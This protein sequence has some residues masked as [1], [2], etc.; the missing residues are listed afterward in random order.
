MLTT[1]ASVQ[2]QGNG[3]EGTLIMRRSSSHLASRNSSWG[4][5]FSENSY[6]EEDHIVQVDSP[7]TLFHV[8]KS[9]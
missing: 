6:C 3:A 7:N 2:L 8:D 4:E 1:V 5:E 9:E